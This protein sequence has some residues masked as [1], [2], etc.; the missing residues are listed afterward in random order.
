MATS[1]PGATGI[2]GEAPAPLRRFN[3]RLVPPPLPQ[4][5]VGEATEIPQMKAPPVPAAPVGTATAVDPAEFLRAQRPPLGTPQASVSPRTASWTGPVTGQAVPNSGGPANWADPLGRPAPSASMIP[6]GEATEHAGAY[7]KGL[8]AGATVRQ[9]GQTAADVLRS[10][11]GRAVTGAAGVVGAGLGAYEAGAAA[12]R[13][14]WAGAAGGAADLAAGGALALG[15]PVTAALGGAWLAGRGIRSGVQAYQNN[16]DDKTLANGLPAPNPLGENAHMP[17]SMYNA[18]LDK[19]PMPSAMHVPTVGPQQPRSADVV[20]AA[21]APNGFGSEVEGVPGAY[22]IDAPGKNP[23]YTDLGQPMTTGYSTNAIGGAPGSPG[24]AFTASALTGP[25]GNYNVPAAA[26]QPQLQGPPGANP[27]QAAMLRAKIMDM[28]TNQAKYG[29]TAVV[30]QAIAAMQPLL[31]QAEGNS[32]GSIA[33]LREGGDMARARM[34]QG[35][36]LRGQDLDMYGKQLSSN[37]T[38]A[39]ARMEQMQKDRAYQLD[40][41]KFGLD[42]AKQRLTQRDSN[43]AQFKSKIEAMYPGEDGKPDANKVA[44]ATRGVNAYLDSQVQRAQQIAQQLPPGSPEQRA[45]LDAVEQLQTGGAN[46]IDPTRLQQLLKQL[47]LQG[48][49]EAGHSALNPFKPGYVH[50]D[51]PADYNITGERKGLIQDDY[52]TAN[53]TV[54]PKRMVNIRDGGVIPTGTGVQDKSFDILKRTIR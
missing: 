5:P 28:A 29:G 17:R 20:G 11:A 13:G 1:Y 45:A 12:K 16:Q 46:A 38:R 30:R 53:G 15:G 35:T 48:K 18:A 43:A 24:S 32:A 33:S 2:L 47:E 36:T 26:D 14:D 51:N 54:I 21:A 41:E 50:S 22:R 34:L 37:T 19:M 44:L 8:K 52:V 25:D 39:I 49:A 27:G 42:V 6:V 9:L 31:D 23:L 3:P 10:P 40:V 4:I 7:G